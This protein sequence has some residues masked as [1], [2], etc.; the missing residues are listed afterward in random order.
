MKGDCAKA[1]DAGSKNEIST[2]RK[3]SFFILI[4]QFYCSDG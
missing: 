4:I 3:F 1:T 2:I